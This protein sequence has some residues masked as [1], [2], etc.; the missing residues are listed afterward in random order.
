VRLIE[1]WRSDRTGVVRQM[2]ICRADRTGVGKQTTAS[3][4]LDNCGISCV[5]ARPVTGTVPPKLSASFA[6]LSLTEMAST[7][8]GETVHR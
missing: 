5:P 2:E 7:K 8:S 4:L 1:G 6:S 3:R